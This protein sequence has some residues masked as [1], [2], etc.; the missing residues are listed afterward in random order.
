MQNS[1]VEQAQI[2]TE[3]SG[4]NALKSQART[5][6][7]AAL[8]QVAKQFESLFMSQMLK[9]MRSANKVLSEGNYLNSSQTEF[10]EDMFDSQLSQT[11]AQKEGMGLS[12][13]L[14]RQLSRQIPGMNTEGDPLASQRRSIADYDRS[15]PSLSPRLPQELARV[16]E[17]SASVP[18]PESMVAPSGESVASSGPVA[19]QAPMPAR[20]DSPE[21][22]VSHLLPIAESV[23]ADSGI[24]P[25]LMVA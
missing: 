25:Q 23:G 5:D 8:E 2:Y 11:M 12:D 7:K 3:F 15:L 24:S 22:F 19:A 1:R 6:K 16:R 18:Q 4:L 21:D 10:Y 20:F 14:V 13:T 17:I 9:T